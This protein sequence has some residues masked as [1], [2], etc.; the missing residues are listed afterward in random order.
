M[1]VSPKIRQ[2]VDAFK[3][4]FRKKSLKRKILVLVVKVDWLSII[5]LLYNISVNLA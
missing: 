4:G 1:Q 5:E 2:T 3:Y